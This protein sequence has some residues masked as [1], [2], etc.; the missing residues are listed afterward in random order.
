MKKIDIFI[1]VYLN[2]ILIY[3]KDDGNGHVVTVWWVLKEFKKFSLYTNLN[4]CWF[5][6]NKIQF[7]GYMVFLEGICIED[8]LIKAIK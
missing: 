7:L 6:Q 3:T 5:H 4:K 2:D 1:I 8:K